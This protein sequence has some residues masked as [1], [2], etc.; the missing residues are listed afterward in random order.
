MGLIKAYRLVRKLKPT[1]VIGFGGYPSVPG[2]F[3][4]QRLGIPTIIH[5]QNA[6]IGR[7][8]GFLARRAN[9][10]ALSWPEIQGLEDADKVRAVVTG[11]P[12][13]PEIA[14][15]FTQAYP[16]AS[17]TGPLRVFIMGGSLGA[18]VFS[19]VVPKA[20]ARLSPDY[21]ARLEIVQQ[22][23]EADIQATREAYRAAGI[24]AEL[25]TFFTDVA[26]E[27]GKAHLVIA[28]SGA[29]TVAEVTTAG[30]PAIFVPYPHHK[31]QQ[32]K[33]NADAVSDA[34]GAWTMTESGFT[35]D[36]LLARME[37]FL[38]NPSILFRAAEKAR[39]CG[40]PDAA[41]KLGNLVT[42]MVSGWK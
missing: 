41:R 33:I 17:D 38:Q 15:L 11:N 18:S 10:I 39:S 23:R 35:P 30:R 5:E 8:N 28:R 12:V 26:G 20:L 1:L 2:V 22:C 7:A 16:H 19:T 27:L 37:T 14:A 24:K 40:K 9:R 4:A 36:A 13:R 3:A 32:Q 6:I 29:S 42:E 31:D 25:E 21:R 34:G